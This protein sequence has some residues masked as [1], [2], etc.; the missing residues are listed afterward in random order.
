MRTLACLLIC[1]AGC[2]AQRAEDEVLAVYKQMERAEQAGDDSAWIAL[3][4]RDSI[5]NAE[6]I[7]PIFRARPDAHYTSSRVFVQGDQ[8]AL[9]G[10]ISEQTYLSMLLVKEDG[11]WK[12][13]D[14]MWNGNLPDANSV[15]AMIPPPDGAFA[16]AGSPWQ[17][18]AT[19]M[20]AAD[21]AARG[22]QI[23]AVFDESFLYVRIESAERLPAPGS[24]GSK[25]PGGWPVMKISI[26]GQGDFVLNGTANIG[27]R[28]TFDA[29]GKANS[30]FP[31]ISY[32]MR[33]EKNDRVIFNA[34]AGLRADPLIHVDDRFLDMRIPLRTLGIDGASPAKIVI[35]DAQWPKTAIFSLTAVRYR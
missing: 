15:Y 28:A 10:E 24:E 31:F 21:A 20:S 2:S 34:E 35:G 19:G 22:W 29:N 33:L 30:H 5:A 12:I 8:A 6:K 14:Q 18:V 26:A 11:R 23:R 27:D 17:N 25:P 9:I 13:K 4:S 7:R 32:W 16:R 1:T 3:W